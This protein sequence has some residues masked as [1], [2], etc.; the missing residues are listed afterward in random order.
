LDFVEFYK[1]P[2][3]RNEF[4]DITLEVEEQQVFCHKIL[5]SA[6]CPYFKT[7]FASGLKEAQQSLIQLQ[8]CAQF[9]LL[10]AILEFIYTD[11]V[12]NITEDIVI[13]L[14][15]TS[16]SFELRRLKSIVENVCGYSLDVDN[17]G[18][19]LD[20][21]VMYSCDTLNRACMF[22]ILRDYNKV[23]GT[24]AWKNMSEQA[25]EV[26]KKQSELWGTNWL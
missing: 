17:V 8:N 15:S 19:L 23:I 7:M 12:E 10:T 6:R 11:D 9:N 20:I 21:A 2:S 14:L 26:V 3:R 22:F 1:D 24:E 25:L 4:C 18:C 5:L 13:D 16:H